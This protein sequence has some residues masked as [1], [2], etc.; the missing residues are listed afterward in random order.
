[1]K[2]SR[3]ETLCE[4]AHGFHSNRLHTSV[5]HGGCLVR[6]RWLFGEGQPFRPRALDEG[7]FRESELLSLGGLS[8]KCLQCFMVL[9]FFFIYISFWLKLSGREG[10][11][12][13]G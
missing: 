12:A 1:M 10:I 2:I 4:F 13:C 5:V 11:L 7:G 8:M 3:I 6:G 9:H